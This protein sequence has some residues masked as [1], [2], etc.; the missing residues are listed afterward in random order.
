[1][2]NREFSKTNVEF[3]NACEEANIASLYKALVKKK[4]TK[5]AVHGAK[6]AGDLTRQASKWR[7]KKGL[8]YKTSK[9]IL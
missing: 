6:N 5:A 2:T 3:M 9:G 4:G 1:M 8:A 7:L